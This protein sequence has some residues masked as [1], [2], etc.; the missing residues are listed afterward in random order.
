MKTLLLVDDDPVFLRALSRSMSALGYEILAADSIAAARELL[1]S[2]YPDFAIVDLH[3]GQDNGNNLIEFLSS[4]FPDTRSLVLSG[5]ANIPNAVASV[6]LGAGD[7]LP[8][9]IDAEELDRALRRL[10][11][12]E[13]PIPENWDLPDEVRLK[14]IV[15]YWEK[16][17]R[18]VSETAR[19]LNMHR[20]T[21]Q[22][23]LRRAE[24]IS[25]ERDPEAGVSQF[26]KIRRRYLSQLKVLAYR[27]SA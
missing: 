23:V 26:Q 11:G 14:H 8:K 25:T 1:S 10:A 3:L 16:N 6:R 13:T 27:N 18:N 17:D 9:P 15:S 24:T 22:R 21:L 4:E 5:Y 7:C 19:K 20:R 2:T 12:E